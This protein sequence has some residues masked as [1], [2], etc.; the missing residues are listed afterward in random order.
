MDNSERDQ[1][2]MTLLV[3]RGLFAKEFGMREL[4]EVSRELSGLGNPGDLVSW[5]LISK[6]YVYT[7]QPAKPGEIARAGGGH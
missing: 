4:V 7:G 1:R 5:T 6:D 2:A 3:N